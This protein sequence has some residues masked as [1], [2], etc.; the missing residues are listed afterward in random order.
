MRYRSNT[1]KDGVKRGPCFNCGAPA[2]A[3]W[4][5]RATVE[6]CGGCA[7]D[8]LPALIADAVSASRN[9]TTHYMD[10]VDKIKATFWQAV[11][12]RIAVEA[13]SLAAEKDRPCRPLAAREVAGVIRPA[14]DAVLWQ[15]V[16]EATNGGGSGRVRFFV[17]TDSPTEL[18]DA[19]AA[20]EE[21]GGSTDGGLYAV[22]EIK[23]TDEWPA[24]PMAGGL[25]IADVVADQRRDK[26]GH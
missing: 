16:G 5:G 1:P 24:A 4:T 8:V 14:T 26:A 17:L 20:F 15:V 3:M 7:T 6:V 21:I 18:P 19:N 11:A 10:A 12:A 22:D 2:D 13:R 23:L 25:T 9:A